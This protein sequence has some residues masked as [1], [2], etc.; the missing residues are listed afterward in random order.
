MIVTPEEVNHFAAFLD[1]YEE[2]TAWNR[3][4]MTA[5]GG[6]T[7]PPEEFAKE[8]LSRLTPEQLKR[9]PGTGRLDSDAVL[10][11][12]RNTPQLLIPSGFD[13]IRVEP[14][15]ARQLAIAF[16]REMAKR[17]IGEDLTQSPRLPSH[18]AFEFMLGL[19][20]RD[21]ATGAWYR[22]AHVDLATYSLALRSASGGTPRLIPFRDVVKSCRGALEGA[23]K[24]A[25]LLLPNLW[26]PPATA[27]S[28]KIADTTRELVLALKRQDISFS[29]L[30]WQQLEDVVAEVL[31]HRG[32]ELQVTPRSRDGG[33]DIVARGEMVPGEYGL[34][35]IEVK[36][37]PVVKLQ[38]IRSHLY[39]NKDFPVLM[40][41]TSGRFTA[42]VVRE[43]QSPENF[44][45]LHLRDG[46]AVSAWI[47]DYR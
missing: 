37:R 13:E 4:F 27:P 14:E 38:D 12:L 9:G 24:P 1:E 28:V 20:C 29:H 17:G 40:V 43:K 6:I 44:L 26:R 16:C 22:T 15:P 36:H 21:T 10:A 5:R 35:A 41:A 18:E 45:R 2:C 32:F 7:D 33:R 23:D 30:S 39:A 11:Y 3:A 31:R 8:V 25:V 47:H 42:G 46:E 19:H 34:V